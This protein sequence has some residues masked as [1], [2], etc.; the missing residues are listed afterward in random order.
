MAK[1]RKTTGPYG[2]A[3][4]PKGPSAAGAGRRDTA[5]GDVVEKAVPADREL[6]EQ[7]KSGFVPWL[8]KY[9][10]PATSLSEILF[11]LIMTLTFTLG[12]AIVV[13]D[14]GRDG[15]RELLVAALGCNI[16]WGI[17]DACFYLI[18]ATFEREQFRRLGRRM[19][20]VADTATAAGML[21]ARFDELLAL[22][23]EQGERKVLYERLARNIRSSPPMSGK[24]QKEDWS[25]AIA[26]GLLVILTT[27]PAALP[28][29]FIDDA[30][31]AMRTSNAI[32]LLTL[33]ATGYGWARYTT[34]RPFVVGSVFLLG[35]LALVL[36]AIPLG[37]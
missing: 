4:L 11:G 36:I 30:Y 19:R 24:L 20:E 12:A 25:G 10:D 31:T 1:L 7:R 23:L 35:G 21:E 6:V 5:A 22:G 15:A 37:G 8:H 18:T 9:I 26:S 2:S 33:F 29:A 16:A 14:E 28:F 27:L 13:Q 17:I 3:S 32:L 34:M